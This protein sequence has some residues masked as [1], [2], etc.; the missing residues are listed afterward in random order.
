ML[1]VRYELN[2]ISNSLFLLMDSINIVH[3]TPTTRQ[4][5]NMYFNK[6]YI[7]YALLLVFSARV[8]HFL[9]CLFSLSNSSVL[10]FCDKFLSSCCKICHAN[11]MFTT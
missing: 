11:C 3:M 5:L 6:L 9:S 10:S 8:I 1:Y 2:T 7:Y 4:K